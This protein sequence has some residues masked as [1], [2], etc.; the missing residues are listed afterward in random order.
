MSIF[1]KKNELP[2]EY[3]K[4]DKYSILSTIPEEHYKTAQN[5]PNKTEWRWRL[6]NINNRSVIEISYK[7]PNKE[8]EYL[9]KYGKW[10]TYEEVTEFNNY[11]EDQYYVYV[12]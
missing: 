3:Y 9:N 4:L 8:R 2:V 11:L 6:F 7:E 5:F 12:D 1:Y 10:I